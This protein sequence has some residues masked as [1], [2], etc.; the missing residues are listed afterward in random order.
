MFF[1]IQDSTHKD[2][3]IEL[4]PRFVTCQESPN[5]IGQHPYAARAQLD[6][7]TSLSPCLACSLMFVTYF[8]TCG[9]LNL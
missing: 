5:N 9:A 2:G 8:V 3:D 4:K 6:G 1:L 7:T